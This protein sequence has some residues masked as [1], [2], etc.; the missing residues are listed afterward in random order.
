MTSQSTH[1]DEMNPPTPPDQYKPVQ[2]QYAV[3]ALLLEI[4]E[5]SPKTTAGE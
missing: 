5:R 2:I 4:N 1:I 3:G